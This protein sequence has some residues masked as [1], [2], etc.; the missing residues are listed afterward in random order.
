MRVM[1]HKNSE[2]IPHKFAYVG[3]FVYDTHNKIIK[4]VL[5]ML[6][7]INKNVYLCSEFETML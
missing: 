2:K 5:K 1:N 4:K 7:Y 3:F 6:A